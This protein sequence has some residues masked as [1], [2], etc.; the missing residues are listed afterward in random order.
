RWSSIPG[1]RPIPV[2]RTVST[3]SPP[4]TSAASQILPPEGVYLAA[5]LRRLVITCSRRWGSAWGGAG[6]AGTGGGRRGRRVSHRGAARPGG[7]VEHRG[8]LDPL[9]PQLNGAAADAGQVEQVVDQVGEPAHLPLDDLPRPPPGAL[10][11]SGAAQHL[12]GVA[13]GGERVAELVG[14]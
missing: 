1:A 6:A 9:A 13:Q 4:W 2:S 10:R 8:E 11:G 12:G 3:T 5:L 7:V 14:E